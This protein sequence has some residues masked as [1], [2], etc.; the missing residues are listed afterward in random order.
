MTS[1]RK[2]ETTK[3]TKEEEA[4]VEEEIQPQDRRIRGRGRTTGKFQ[5]PIVGDKADWRPGASIIPKLGVRTAGGDRN[6]RRDEGR[7]PKKPKK[8]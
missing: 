8:H 1:Q 3:P 2:K 5:A 4:V 7:R 6:K